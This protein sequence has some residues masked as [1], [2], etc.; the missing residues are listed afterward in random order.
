MTGL[1]RPVHYRKQ[2][3]APE[4]PA[5]SAAEVA[6]AQPAA[7]ARSMSTRRRVRAIYALL[8]RRRTPR[9]TR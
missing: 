9:W 3:P 2:P 7:H 1:Y 8:A 5:A 4:A 6:N